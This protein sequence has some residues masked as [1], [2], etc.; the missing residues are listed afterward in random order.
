MAGLR[1]AALNGLFEEAARAAG[2]RT[3]LLP[4]V[5]TFPAR[6]QITQGQ[7][8]FT[9]RLY[10][11]T[12]THGGNTRSDEEFRIQLTRVPN[13]LEAEPGGKTLLMGWWPEAEVFAAWDHNA[14]NG[15]LGNSPSCQVALGTLRK[16]SVDG[17]AFQYRDDPG[18][19]VVAFRPEM[20]GVYL[21]QTEALHRA[22]VLGQGAILLER[23]AADPDSVTDSQI[24]EDSDAERRRVMVSVRRAARAYRFSARV[25]EAYGHRCAF[26]GV[27]LH[28]LDAAHILPVAHQSSV[29]KT[30]N[31]IAVCTLHHR[32]YDNTLITFD[33][34]G[35]VHVNATQIAEL[36][37]AGLSGG[38][39]YFKAGLFTEVLLPA[40][41]ADRPTA[42]NIKA[43]N[44]HR[45]WK[46]V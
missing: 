12:V 13:Y 43:A 46:K 21:G 33:Q 9:A 6:Y 23:A 41:A 7:E 19:Y 14:H 45:G 39:K 25:M 28:L 5:G 1:K 3:L 29:D 37:K 40:N 2:W 16:A 11:W 32:A 8:G 31:G 26:C 42:A 10:I 17:M 27:Q 34:R 18:E 38:L 30:S 36:K 35:R 15:A 22:G 24:D 4:P 44:K 20:M